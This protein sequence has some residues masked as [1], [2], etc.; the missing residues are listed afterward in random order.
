[1]LTDHFNIQPESMDSFLED[2][3]GYVNDSIQVY[4]ELLLQGLTSHKD[5][6]QAIP[7]F[8]SIRKIVENTH[9]IVDLRQRFLLP[10]ADLARA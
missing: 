3:Q 2:M 10:E 1:M 5:Y 4:D 9:S 7:V 6:K 8:N